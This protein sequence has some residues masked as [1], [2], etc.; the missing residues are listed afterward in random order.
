MKTQL[1]LATLSA[2]LMMAFALPAFAQAPDS[3]ECAANADCPDGYTCEVF[4]W[5][6]CPACAEGEEC[7]PCEMGSDSVCIPPPPKQCSASSDCDGTDVCVTYTFESCSG[8]TAPACDPNGTCDERP[9]EPSTCETSSES[10]CVPAYAAPCQVAA[11][12]GGGFTCEAYDVCTCS[13]GGSTGE[14]GDGAPP[15]P[16]EDDC[17][18]EASGENY[19]QLIEVECSSD[20]DC[21]GELTC[22]EAYS[23]G[24]GVVCP[25]GEE[26]PDQP[27]EPVETVS[28]CA[29]DGY[30]YYG[31]GYAEAVADAAG[32]DGST[33]T[34][35]EREEFFPVDGTDDGSGSK[36]SPSSCSTAAGVGEGSLLFLLAGLMLGRRRRRS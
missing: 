20:A 13:G 23:V 3:G 14:P 4:E 35:S 33:V 29:P 36:Q 16:V 10:Y 18:C 30:G 12:C 21:A 27:P 17:V 34:K 25:D 6:A 7:P 22:Q 24:A 5:G 2:G 31:G 8:E 1:K 28:Y 32:R 11:D 19:C 15:E 26:C 9:P